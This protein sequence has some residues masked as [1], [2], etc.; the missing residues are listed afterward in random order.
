MAHLPSPITHSKRCAPARPVQPTGVQPGFTLIELLVVIAIISIL[1]ALLMPAVK[2]AHEKAKT[3]SCMSNLRQL[4]LGGVFAYAQDHDEELTCGHRRMFVPEVGAVT[5]VAPG[6]VFKDY[7]DIPHKHQGRSIYICPSEPNPREIV[8][9]IPEWAQFTY[10][11]NQRGAK[12]SWPKIVPRFAMSDLEFPSQSSLVM[13]TSNIHSYLYGSGI[14][15]VD[16]WAIWSWAPRHSEGM[17][18]MFVDGHVERIG[19]YDV[20]KTGNDVFFWWYKP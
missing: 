1:A 16:W 4:Y 13:D 10:G 14:Y 7:F 19:V 8:A 6:Y 20:P 2:N 17:N 15:P 5:Q 18:V 12:G 11:F 9:L 3:V